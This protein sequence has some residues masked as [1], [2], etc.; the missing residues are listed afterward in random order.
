MAASASEQLSAL[1]QAIELLDE[2]G[3]PYWLFGGWA[4]DFYVSAVTRPHEDVDIAVWLKDVPRLHE[5]LVSQGWRHTPD[6]DDD[7]GT[8]FEYGEVRLGLTF[9]A[10]DEDGSI[11]IPLRDGRIDW[12]GEVFGD[13]TRNFEG[14]RARVVEFRWLMGAKAWPRGDAVDQAKDR[15]DLGH[16]RKLEGMS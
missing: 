8:G 5:L 13:S 4:V 9:L 10:Q 1:E 7:G 15:A 2:A 14:V 3:I 16:L 11:F 6:V 12:Q